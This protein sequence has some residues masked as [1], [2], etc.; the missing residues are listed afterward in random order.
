M[1]ILGAHLVRNSGFGA[2][3]KQ[4]LQ[5]ILM[6]AKRFLFAFFFF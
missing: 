5:V 4:I 3:Q 1:Q 2:Q 6:N